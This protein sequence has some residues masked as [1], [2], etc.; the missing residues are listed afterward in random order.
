M[1][2]IAFYLTYPFIYLIA[3]LPFDA[4]YKVSDILYYLLRLTGYRQ[5]VVLNNLRNS[6]PEKSP[7]EIETLS[8][9]FYRYLCDLILETLKTLKMTEQESRDHCTF[10]TPEWLNKLYDEK[11]SFIIV[12][13][14]YGN[15]E[16]AGPSFTLNTNFQLVVIY[17][18]L[19][20][21]YFEKMMVRTRT[22]FGTRITPVNLTLRDMVA[23]R[24][25]VTATAFIADQT[26]PHDKAYWTSFLHQDTAVFTGPEK[27]AIKFDYP[28]V[29]MNVKRVRRGYYEVTPEMLF[30]K[31]QETKENE[32]SEVFMNRLERE[33]LQDPS[34]WLWSHRR[35]KHA[36][37]LH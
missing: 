24:K 9:A 27:L 1:Q 35:W 7:S 15:W 10:H 19:T 18:P 2:A 25:L 8:K 21:T 6:F 30:P 28:V 20:N 29:Y 26:A 16:W 37:P 23:N 17:R 22:R 11:K 4:L 31:P 5:K 12:M 32:I 34:I 13:G 3:S 14:H 36:R 33:I